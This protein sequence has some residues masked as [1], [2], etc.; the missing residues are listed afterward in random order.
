[1]IRHRFCNISCGMVFASS[2]IVFVSFGF[3]MALHHL[4]SFLH[5]LA[6][7]CHGFVSFGIVLQIIPPL[8]HLQDLFIPA[9]GAG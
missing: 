1:M 3:G 6:S 5:H 9:A 4:A 7:F 8:P 2:G